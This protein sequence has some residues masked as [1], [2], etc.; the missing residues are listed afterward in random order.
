TNYRAR[1][2]TKYKS[3]YGGLLNTVDPVTING[4]PGSLYAAIEAELDIEVVI[5]NAPNLDEVRVYEAN[6]NVAQILPML[7]RMRSDQ[8]TIV[9]DSWGLCEP[10]LPPSFLEAESTQLQ[11]LAIEQVGGVGGTTGI[12]FFSATGDSGSSDCA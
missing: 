12:S 10:A 9:S 1:H 4:G 5:S 8:V 3:C 11:L 6:N 2:I 7:E